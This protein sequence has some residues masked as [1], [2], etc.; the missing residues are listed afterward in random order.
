MN[1]RDMKLTK[2]FI[3][4]LFLL[5]LSTAV[6][7]AQDD[8][9][10]AIKAGTIMPVTSA[11]IEDGVILIRDGK[12]TDIGTNLSIPEG[13]RV[14]DA[15]DKVV[16]PGLIDAMTTL[17]N[18]RADDDESVTPDIRALD[19]FDFF[20]K[21]RRLLAGGVTSVHVAP[22]RRRLIPGY[23]AVVKLA[24][25]TIL[26][27]TLQEIA[28][29]SVV[30]G[31]P[32][33]LP[34]LLFDPPIPPGPENQIE[35]AEPQL[36]TTRMGEMALL[37]YTF[38]KAKWNR[39]HQLDQ[40]DLQELA[41][42]P[43]LEGL[44]ALRVTAHT[45][46]DIR[47]ALGFARAYDVRLIIEGATE[48]YKVV[49]DIK[50][51]QAS[52][53]LDIDLQP[54]RSHPR[55]NSRDR[56]VGQ[57]NPTNSVALAE[58]NIPFALTSPTDQTS[59][60]L[61]FIAGY[62][63]GQGLTRDQALQSITIQPA[64]ILGVDRRVGSIERGKDAD[65]VIL[66]AEPFSVHSVVEQTLVNGQFVY[67]RPQPDSQPTEPNNPILAIKAG[68]LFTASHGQ[69]APGLIL[70]E[71]GKIRYAGKPK[72]IPE[73]ATVIDAT[74]QVVVP[75]MI[76]IHSH[77]G[78]HADSTSV[79]PRASA[80]SGSNSSDGRLASIA[81]AVVPDD[82]AYTD[83]LRSGVTSI[84]LAPPAGQSLV[85]GNA[86]LIKLA[87]PTHSERIVKD[88]AAVKFSMRGGS[89]RMARI[90]EAR[91]L[92]KRAKAYADRW[93]DYERKEREYQQRKARSTPDLVK[94]PAQPGRDTNLELLRGLFK[95]NMP[96][97][98]QA[99]RDDEIR[100]TLTVFQDEY[101][102]D[103]ILLGARYGYRLITDLRKYNVGLALGPDIIHYDKEK[104]INN[105][106]L[107]T[108]KG[109]RVAL[110]TS[111]TSGTQYLPVNAAF[112][113]R[114]G[115]DPDQA[116]QA[117]T[118]VPARL[119]HVE[120]RLGSIDIGKD[121]DL[122]I[123]SGDPLELTTQVQQVLIDGTVVYRRTAP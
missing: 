74:S 62:A 30:L 36:P 84:L 104:P 80:T 99:D 92:L 16:I 6:L 108:Q 52:L 14:I 123:L 113:V 3:I 58:A 76:D 13:A 85:C 98:I 40:V 15:S 110:Q 18:D 73:A 75:G 114:H 5:L 120:D 4:A 72:D 115:M 21:Y 111:A 22:G 11:P 61:R 96:A 117:V 47:N 54:G 42:W 56:T 35:P 24:G 121:A 78:L 112:A 26:N 51:S 32:P 27:R 34:P 116:F 118:L 88:F 105:A 45:A 90:W 89:P 43:V 71:Q 23:G 101:N 39:Q 10:L 38:A 57:P 29:L 31:E 12:I 25:E 79:R 95:R 2:I 59:A 100:N 33:K 83:A 64:R 28:G 109:L 9:I 82:P 102:L 97:L 44:Q 49:G 1:V 106:A 41:L 119:L 68:K 122:V 63:I 87:A 19:A 66:T 46:Q 55:D 60:D 77:L 81:H 93:K 107:L 50:A 48:A 91:D 65:L 103:V 70:I 7:A 37:R 67:Q 17:T 69:I 86:A 94:P 8:D 53:I 20:G